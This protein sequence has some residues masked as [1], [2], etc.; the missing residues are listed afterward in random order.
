MAKRRL[1]TDQH[2]AVPV[3]VDEGQNPTA[4]TR[5]RTLVVDTCCNEA[6]R[7]C[8]QVLAAGHKRGMAGA[9]RLRPNLQSG[10]RSDVP[11]EKSWH[12]T[13]VGTSAPEGGVPPLGCIN[14]GDGRLS[15]DSVYTHT[16]RTTTMTAT[17]R[18]A[19]RK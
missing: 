1:R 6:G 7:L 14:V 3:G 12:R 15:E 19:D 16:D 5:L 9:R 18:P 17:H 2:D 8:V 10:R 4:A 13:D 11:L